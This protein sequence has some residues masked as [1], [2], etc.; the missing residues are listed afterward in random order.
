MTVFSKRER[1]IKEGRKERV[2]S[3][4]SSTERELLL[5]VERGN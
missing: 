2:A 1:C 5:G 4:D 3:K